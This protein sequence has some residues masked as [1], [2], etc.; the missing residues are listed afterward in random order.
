MGAFDLAAGDFAALEE[1]I[2]V[3]E[4]SFLDLILSR[5]HALPSERLFPSP[6]PE[7]ST[8]RVQGNTTDHLRVF[9]VRSNAELDYVAELLEKRYQWRGY[10]APKFACNKPDS[11]APV[12]STQVTLVAKYGDAALGTLTVGVDSS[13]AGLYVEHCFPEEVSAL[14]KQSQRLA[15]L[16]R[17]AVDQCK[18]SRAILAGLFQAAYVVCRVENNV[19]DVL[20][21]VNPRHVAFYRRAFGFLPAAKERTSPR[22]GASSVLMRLEM[23]G[24]DRRLGASVAAI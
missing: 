3:Q 22:V 19:S 15:E 5:T 14:R 13:D 11:D 23:A 20:I 8:L 17:L 18:H 7:R 4:K 21:E 6:E 1:G 2:L 10:A 9:A 16:T 12:P 24:L